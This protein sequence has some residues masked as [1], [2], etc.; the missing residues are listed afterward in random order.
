MRTAPICPRTRETVPDITIRRAWTAA[1]A[2]ALTGEEQAS[3]LARR[4]YDLRHACALRALSHSDRRWGGWG[5]N[6]RPADY[7]S[8][9]LSDFAIVL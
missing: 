3:P 7:E 9:V 5:S 6:P 1:R 4:I 8:E 2:E